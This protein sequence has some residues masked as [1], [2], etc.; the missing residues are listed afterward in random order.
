M[1]NQAT[2]EEGQNNPKVMHCSLSFF[3]KKNNLSIEKDKRGFRKRSSS[4]LLNKLLV[5]QLRPIKTIICPSPINLNQKCP[6]KP[7]IL[8]IQNTTI[9]TSSFDSQNDFNLKPIRYIYS[10]RKI[11]K[12]SSKILNIEEE[13][14]P[15]SDCENN[16][17]K[18]PFLHSDSDTSRSEEENDIIR[19][20]NNKIVN[21]KYQNI[22]I[23][24]KK[25][26]KIRKAYLFRENLLDDSEIGNRFKM[27]ILNDYKNIKKKSFISKIR[28]NKNLKPNGMIKYRTKSFNAKPKLVSTILGFLEKNNSA[29]SLNSSG[30]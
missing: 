13:V 5:P 14:Y 18:G 28:E 20:K 16:S 11:P 26:E 4:M 6:S 3:R 10:R 19:N 7:P 1:E 2:K 27:K 12:K 24:R 21:K 15:I 22:N 23:M 8:E 29:N 17:K 25:M 9:S 30:K